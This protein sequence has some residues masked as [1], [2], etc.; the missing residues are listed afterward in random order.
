M[1]STGQIRPSLESARVA[2]DSFKF[3]LQEII[4]MIVPFALMTIAGVTAFY[5]LD[6]RVTELT[7]KQETMRLIQDVTERSIA[8][9][10]NT[11]GHPG[12]QL[13]IEGIGRSQAVL[14]ERSETTQKNVSEIKALLKDVARD[15]ND[16]KRSQ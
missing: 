6:R 1:G 14:E 15:I 3:S 8:T 10:R 13:K 12:M 4:K 5:D 7:G 11:V 9:H 2:D 16:I